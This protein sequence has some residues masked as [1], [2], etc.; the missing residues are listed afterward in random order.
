M[1]SRAKLRALWIAS[2]LDRLRSAA[3]ELIN[4]LEQTEGALHASAMEGYV[5]A[6]CTLAREACPDCYR[7]WWK[8]RH[9]DAPQFSSSAGI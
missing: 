2:E 6:D 1:K 9:S 7:A 3:A 5:C 8:K 4:E